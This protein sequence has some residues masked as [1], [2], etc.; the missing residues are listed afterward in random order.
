[1]EKISDDNSKNIPVSV[2]CHFEKE[3]EECSHPCE[4]TARQVKTV[5][6]QEIFEVDT[7]CIF[8]T[9]HSFIII[10]IFIPSSLVTIWASYWNQEGKPNEKNQR[11]ITW[12]KF[13]PQR[14]Q[15]SMAYL[16]D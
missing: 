15:F 9:T 5:F 7:D 14:I 4:V 6:W 8:E 11:N 2:V 16:Q 10:N 13:L 3:N 12:K 1:M